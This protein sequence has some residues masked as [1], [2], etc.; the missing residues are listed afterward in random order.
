M[1]KG[2]L[3]KILDI[4]MKRRYCEQLYVNKLENLDGGILRQI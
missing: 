1:E 2:I 3:L 4:K